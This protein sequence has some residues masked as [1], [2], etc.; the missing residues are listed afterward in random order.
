M[1]PFFDEFIGPG[2]A[3]A[4]NGMMSSFDVNERVRDPPEEL[5]V[6]LLLVAVSSLTFPPPCMSNSSN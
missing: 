2:A 6:A 4:A 5:W 1:I 3:V